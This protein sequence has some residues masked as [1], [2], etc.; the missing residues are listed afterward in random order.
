[1][2]SPDILI[3]FFTRLLKAEV[4]LTFNDFFCLTCFLLNFVLSKGN[5]YCL[6]PHSFMLCKANGFVFATI[7]SI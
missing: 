7:V 6:S 4:L 2:G 5:F 3:S 1:M